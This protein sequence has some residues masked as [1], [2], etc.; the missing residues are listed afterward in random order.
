MDGDG[1]TDASSAASTVD[2]VEEVVDVSA[3]ASS[4]EE[5]MGPGSQIG[6]GVPVGG[7]A[8]LQRILCLGGWSA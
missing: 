6:R 4:S 1:F 2:H 8:K 7:V 5:G 3:V